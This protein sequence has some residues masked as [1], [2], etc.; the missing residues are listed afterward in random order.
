MASLVATD[1]LRMTNGLRCSGSFARGDARMALQPTRKSDSDWSKHVEEWTM[2]HDGRMARRNH[3][4]SAHNPHHIGTHQWLQWNEGYSEAM[5][6][7][8]LKAL[9]DA[10]AYHELS[11]R[12]NEKD[13]AWAERLAT[14]F[15][16]QPE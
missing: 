8:R 9:E 16:Q 2:K 14:Q 11:V 3:G 1:A 13:R 15:A 10:A 6:S 4:V 12:D 7:A 5:W